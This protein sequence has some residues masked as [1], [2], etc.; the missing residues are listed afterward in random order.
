MDDALTAD[1]TGRTGRIQDSFSSSSSVFSPLPSI[2]TCSATWVWFTRTATW[3][4]LFIYLFLRRNFLLFLDGSSFSWWDLWH[5]LWN[6]VWPIMFLYKQTVEYTETPWPLNRNQAAQILLKPNFY[7]T[8]LRKS[9]PR[10][11]LSAQ[12]HRRP[13]PHPI[14]VPS[15]T[16][17]LSLYPLHPKI[18]LQTSP[19]RRL[20]CTI[21]T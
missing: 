12:L 10:K 13:T 17:G 20:W 4:F 2:A 14:R 7:K 11:S 8:L 5:D 15:Q 16:Q 21:W 9:S 3:N 18:S 1:A 6:S 19:L